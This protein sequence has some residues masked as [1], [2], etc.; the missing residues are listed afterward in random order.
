MKTLASLVLLALLAVPAF[1]I[2]PTFPDG[3][4][5]FETA[6]NDRV[7]EIDGLGSPSAT[8][9]KERG[10]LAKVAAALGNYA[11]GTG[12]SE[13]GLAA[14]SLSS[15]YKTSMAAGTVASGA[16]DLLGGIYS[17]ITAARNGAVTERDKLSDQKNIDKIDAAIAKAD[18]V[19]DAAQSETDWGK[20]AKAYAKA[21][22]AFDKAKASAAKL[23]AKEA[24]A[25]A[26]NPTV[27]CQWP[28]VNFVGD[29]NTSTAAWNP[30][31]GGFGLTS[32]MSG[33][34]RYVLTIG[35]AGVFAP[36]TF[37]IAGGSGGVAAIQ[38]LTPVNNWLIT[39]GSITI[40]SIS[41]SGA[42]GT[43]TFNALSGLTGAISVTAGVFSVPV[44]Q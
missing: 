42:S 2:P 5:R 28:G 29:K 4:D 7:A 30:G 23:V 22:A 15:A 14:K 20:I 3:M 9:L 36:G 41:A 12:K 35:V 10:A 24:A 34:T 21:I 13:L 39:G 31:T 44:A 37:A 17:L 33:A 43:F 32:Q 11:G 40:N 8:E 19:I 6:I 26:K 27:T 16:T 38:G 25:A 18:A 1:A